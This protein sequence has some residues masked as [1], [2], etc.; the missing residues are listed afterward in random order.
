MQKIG[1]PMAIQDEEI[2]LIVLKLV[3]FLH[4]GD[5]TLSN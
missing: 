1:N 3:A 5:V 2:M 4:S